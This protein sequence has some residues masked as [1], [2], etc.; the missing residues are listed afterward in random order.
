M[1][2]FLLAHSMSFTEMFGENDGQAIKELII[3][4]DTIKAHK[5][6]DDN[7]SI[8]KTINLGVTDE[9]ITYTDEDGNTYEKYFH[10][11]SLML[12]IAYPFAANEYIKSKDLIETFKLTDS[13]DKY[14]DFIS[15]LEKAEDMVIKAKGTI[16]HLYKPMYYKEAVRKFYIQLS[17]D[18]NMTGHDTTIVKSLVKILFPDG[19]LD[20]NEAYEKEALS[21]MEEQL[22]ELHETSLPDYSPEELGIYNRK[23]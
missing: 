7:P 6:D 19:R 2:S 8:T 14:D 23:E 12:K 16:E 9:V 22:K 3:N 13:K 17:V 20:F 15:Q 4:T 21:I 18:F 1:S 5:I 10:E 11:Q